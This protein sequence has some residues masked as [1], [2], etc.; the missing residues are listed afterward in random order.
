MQ[1]TDGTETILRGDDNL[2]G[3]YF[4]MR[5]NLCGRATMLNGAIRFNNSV[6]ATDVEGIGQALVNFGATD[7]YVVI[8]ETSCNGVV[9]IWLQF[10]LVMLW[11]ESFQ[12]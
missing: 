10:D 7:Y 4:K 2:C 11:F 12:Y 9:C 3:N 6:C 5:G 8:R 1:I